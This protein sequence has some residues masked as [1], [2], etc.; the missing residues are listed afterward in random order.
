MPQVVLAAA[1]RHLDAG[2]PADAVDL[3]AQA[4]AERPG[5][6][7]LRQALIHLLRSLS[8]IEPG[9][10]HIHRRLGD[11]LGELGDATGARDAYHA[12]LLADPTDMAARW[13]G[14]RV[15]PRVYHSPEEIEL[16]RGR[17]VD[18]IGTLAATTPMGDLEE[19][20]RAANGVLLRTNF[21]LA[22]QACDDR[23]VQEVWGR[24]AARAMAR[25]LPDLAAPPPRPERPDGRIRI[26]YASSFFWSHTI[27][28]LFAGWI[29]GADR[30]RFAV[31]VYLPGGRRDATTETLARHADVFRDLR[32]VDMATAARTI[33]DDR[34][35][36]L[37]FPDLGMESRSFVLAALKLAPVVCVGMGHPVTT[38][39]PTVDWFLTSDLMEPEGGEAHYS[40]KLLRLPGTSF[41]YTPNA[42]PPAKGR[43][44]LGLPEDG[45]LYLCCQAQQKYLPQHDGLFPAI[46]ARLPAARFVFIEHRTMLHVNR[47]LRARLERAFTAR[48]LDPSRHLVFLPWL[49]WTDFLDLNAA[50][51]VFLDSVGWS[52]GNTTFEALSRGLPVVTLPDRFMRGRHAM[53]MLRILGADDGIARDADHYVEI[54]V[55]LGADQAFR[56]RQRSIIAA[57]RDR[58]F[59][60]RA[61]IDALEAF[62]REVAG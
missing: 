25:V 11:E 7:G 49:A 51:D 50:C 19:A 41:H 14:G 58:L 38:G 48:G 56:D 43:A 13:L 15:L 26:G 18:A 52:G 17:F 5:E 36:V 42:N 62:Y 20:V 61:P 3:L 2:R 57:G 22:Y 23:P 35:D 45:V 9:R 29:M 53:A 33:R 44:A 31:H 12:A 47:L 32:T 16:W 55:R 40:E 28:L 59:R 60:D 27:S 39:L 21:E 6:A 1:Q 24:L 4:V 30:D 34:L 8:R 46:A 10:P 54:A 37:V